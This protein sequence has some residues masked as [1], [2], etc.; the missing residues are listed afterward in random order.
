MKRVLIVSPHFPPI[1]APDMQRVRMSLPYYEANG[2]EAVV[3]TVGESYQ[4]GV[5]ELELLATLPPGVRI[6][7]TQAVPL[8]LARIFGVGNL[9]LRA[10]LFLFCR[11]VRLL[12]REN[13]DLVFFSN[14]QFIT[15]TLGALWKRWC[16]VPYVVDV[17][18]PWR[19]D[20]YER[21]GSR[22]PPGGWKY[23]F[24]RLQAWAFE[25]RSFTG[26][27]AVV[28]VSPAYL[29]DLRARYP[30]L[31]VKPTAVIRFGASSADLARA[32]ALPAPAYP[33]PRND[34]QV[35]LIYTGASGPIMPHA[36]S[37]LFGGLSLYR[38][39][40]PARATRLKF[41]FVGT[42]YTAPGFGSPSVLPLAEAHG[43]LDLVAEVPHRI[44]FLEALQLQLQADVLLLLGSSD[45]AYSPSKIYQYYLAGRPILGLVFRDS[46]MEHQLDELACAFMVRVREHESRDEAYASLSRFFDQVA[47]GLAPRL[48]PRNDKLFRT[49]YLSEELTRRQCE[50]FDQALATEL[51]PPPA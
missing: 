26:A 42:S 51:S 50:L 17:Q 23:Q 16:G 45:L 41:H 3:L 1:N 5:R 11:G 15:F 35:H 6:V 4:D 13:F 48:P 32:R 27:N 44:G 30:S 20:Y 2:W 33:F 18:D 31:G 47:G 10:W 14:T 21:P 34:G 39:R 25:R 29:D 9:G 22:K 7:A 37:V 46:V 43:V 8:R 38:E 24:A 12:R 49:A 40:E 28:S 19:T 36:L